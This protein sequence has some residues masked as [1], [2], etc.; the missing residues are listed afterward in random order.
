[1]VVLSGT[2]AKKRGVRVHSNGLKEE[3]KIAIFKDAGAGTRKRGKKIRTGS[4]IGNLGKERNETK[5]LNWRSYYKIV[6]RRKGGNVRMERL[7]IRD[8]KEPRLHIRGAK[9]GKLDHRSRKEGGTEIRDSEREWGSKKIFQLPG[10][11]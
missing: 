9:Q 7:G 4:K 1:L 6:K 5:R 2:S 10:R 11:D 8:S 3:K